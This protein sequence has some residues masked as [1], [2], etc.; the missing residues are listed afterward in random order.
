M[1]GCCKLSHSPFRHEHL[2]DHVYCFIWGGIWKRPRCNVHNEFLGDSL[3]L[4]WL[5]SVWHLLT[6]ISRGRFTHGYWRRSEPW[7]GDASLR[8]QFIRQCL[9]SH[10]WFDVGNP[11]LVRIRLKSYYD[12]HNSQITWGF[13]LFHLNRHWFVYGAN[14]TDFSRIVLSLRHAS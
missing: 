11:D 9:S 5:D 6:W 12:S 3:E 1:E 13:Q 7:F 8:F 2:P 10:L 4:A 14:S